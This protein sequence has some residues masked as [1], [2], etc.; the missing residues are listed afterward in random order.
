M[1]L[2][3]HRTSSGAGRESG[4]G[5]F[6][7]AGPVSWA[8]ARTG[9]HRDATGPRGAEESLIAMAG[10]L[11]TEQSM[12]ATLREVLKLACAALA[13]GDEGGITLLAAG[14]PD[15][16]VAT[17][18]VALRLDRTQYAAETGGPCLDAYRRQQ[19]LRIDSTAGETRWPEFSRTAAAEG[20]RSALSVP[21]LVGGDGLGTLNIYCRRENG[22]PA[23]DE[24]IAAALGSCASVT[25]A[26][27][28]AFW[29]AA[30]LA[31][32]LQQSLSTRGAVDK[33]TGILMAQHRCSAEHCLHLLAA[34]AQRNR[35]TLPEVARDLVERTA[36]KQ[37]PA[38]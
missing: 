31:E 7:A 14:G 15:T 27:A 9:G 13:G 34:A 2:P 33:A 20:L 3:E 38:S 12:E 8:G 22:F 32:Q 5:F 23:A 29:R 19:V 25:V 1:T 35:L 30:R 21:L 37:P 16:A 6:S 36:N 26:N 24:R 17:S 4:A 28:R 18:D 11:V 10:I